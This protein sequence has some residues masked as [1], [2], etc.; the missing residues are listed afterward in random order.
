MLD[1]PDTKLQRERVSD[2]EQDH[3]HLGVKTS[4]T[5]TEA[6]QGITPGVVRYVLAASLG[7]SVALSVALFVYVVYFLR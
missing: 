4:R 3:A 7:L 5:P 1:E 6:R 2:S